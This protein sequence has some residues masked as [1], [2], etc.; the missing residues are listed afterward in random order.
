MLAPF[1]AQN[2]YYMANTWLVDNVHPYFIFNQI[3]VEEFR[4]L[5]LQGTQR[6]NNKT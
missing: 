3:G 4:L 2:T 1:I 6:A 5:V